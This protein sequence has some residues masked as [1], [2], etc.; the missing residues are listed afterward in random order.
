MPSTIDH[1]LTCPVCKDTLGRDAQTLR[2]PAGHVFDVAREGY[3]N[4]LPPQHKTRGIEGDPALMVRARRR[5][6]SAGHYDPLRMLLAETV[7]ELLSARDAGR[8]ESAPA[9]VMEVGC[10]EGY[11]IG[12][13]AEQLAL[14]GAAFLGTD[15]SKSAVRAAAKRHRGVL[16]FV[17]DVNRRIYVR[18][19]SVSVLLDVFAPRNP[20]EFARVVEPKGTTVVVI[21]G[22]SHMAS[23]IDQLDLLGIEKD[24]EQRV[25]ERFESDFRLEERRELSYPMV[26]SASAVQDLVD[27]GPSRWH[28]RSKPTGHTVTTEAS[29]VLLE[30]AR[31]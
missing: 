17:A 1:P 20:Q 29:F 31:R 23:L 8:A 2:C 10:G 6:L 22:E 19:G 28:F 30:F 4:L 16:F 21:P 24:K 11:Y 15:L 3:I 12:G 14:R 26:L 27:M 25:V 9:A 18:D 7:G 13:I 5:F